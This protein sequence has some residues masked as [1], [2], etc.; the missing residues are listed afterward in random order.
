MRRSFEARQG[1]EHFTGQLV[2]QTDSS[3]SPLWRKAH[4][5]DDP[6]GQ[7]FQPAGPGD[8]DCQ[9][10]A[11]GSDWVSHVGTRWSPGQKFSVGCKVCS[12]RE[13]ALRCGP[14]RVD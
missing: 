11:D 2:D 7:L 9:V 3:K 4:S 14:G 10:D 8:D 5:P 1:G 13:E 6:P 12:S